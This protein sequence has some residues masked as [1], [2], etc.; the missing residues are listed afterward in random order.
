M[1]LLLCRKKWEILILTWT[2]GGRNLGIL[3]SLWVGNYCP[4]QLLPQRRHQ[5]PLHLMI[6]AVWKQLV[7][8]YLWTPKLLLFDRTVERWVSTIS[9]MRSGVGIINVLLLFSCMQYKNSGNCFSSRMMIRILHFLIMN[10]LS[11]CFLLS[12]KLLLWVQRPPRQ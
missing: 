7:L 10:L 9:A 12:P 11:N 2:S 1:L 4:Y 8:L 5:L 6:V 3:V